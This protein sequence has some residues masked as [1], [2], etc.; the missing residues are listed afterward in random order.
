M[1]MVLLSMATAFGIAYAEQNEKEGPKPSKP[2]A[3]LDIANTEDGAYPGGATPKR[4][5]WKVDEDAVKIRVSPEP[6]ERAWLEFGP[7]IRE[8]GATIVAEGRVPG[9]SRIQSRFG[10]GLYGENG[11]QIEAVPAKGEV[12]LIRRGAVLTKSKFPLDVEKMYTL[13]LSVLSEGDNWRIMGRI[14]DDESERPEK[15]LFSYKIF[16]VELLFPLAG[17]PVLTATPFSGEAA[18]FASAKVYDGIFVPEPADEETDQEGEK[19]GEE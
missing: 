11:F 2:I 13:E 5:T 10:A 18:M 14:W 9:E 12:E 6:L 4:G 16:A 17:R 19:D 3:F 7:E 1:R 15:E 8:K